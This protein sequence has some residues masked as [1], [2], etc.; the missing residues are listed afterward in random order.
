MI[1]IAGGTGFIGQVLAKHLIDMEIPVRL[2]VR[3]SKKTPRLMTGKKLDIAVASLQDE[4]S[5]RAAFTDV[6]VLIHLVSDERRGARADFAGVDIQGTHALIRAA[7]QSRIKQLIYLSHLGADRGSAFAMLKTK[8]I[9]ENSIMHSQ[10]PYTILRSGVVYGPNDQFT[11]PIAQLIKRSAGMVFVPGDGNTL[12]QPVWV[13]DLAACIHWTLDNPNAINQILSVGGGEY[14]TIRQ[15]VIDI[16]QAIRRKRLVVPLG[17]VYL[18][19]LALI[20]EQFI[21]QLPVSINWLDYLA[22]DRTCSVDTLPR[23]F[24]IIPSR[25]SSQLGYLKGK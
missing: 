11:L 8:S 4:R 13:E 9:C 21:G 23:I 17:P 19:N 7:Q 18:R 14:L 6:D 12:I 22:S 16:L 3:P 2:L 24:G 1:L 5:L 20:I 25:F 10:V 15:V